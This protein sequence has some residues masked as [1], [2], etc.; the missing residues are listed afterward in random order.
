MTETITG[1][2]RSA[3]VSFTELLDGDSHPVSDILRAESR[4]GVRDGLLRRPW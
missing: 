1:T 2:D 3:G 4:L